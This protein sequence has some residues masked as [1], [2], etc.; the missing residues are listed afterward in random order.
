M[1][2]YKKNPD[3]KTK[4]KFHL[5]YFEKNFDLKFRIPQV[6]SCSMCKKLGISFKVVI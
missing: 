3:G 6:D 4:Y 5:K 2:P 1:I